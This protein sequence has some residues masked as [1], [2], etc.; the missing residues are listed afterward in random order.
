MLRWVGGAT[1]PQLRKILD[2]GRVAVLGSGPGAPGSTAYGEADALLARAERLYGAGEDSSAAAVYEM[3]LAHA[4]PE[5][6]S[7]SRAVESLLFTLVQTDA[8]L[9]AARLARD[10]YPHLSRTPSAANVAATG[11]DCALA[12]PADSAGRAELVA[13]LEADA[14][15]VVADSTV[16]VAADDRSAVYIALLDA[17]DDAKDAAGKRRW[18]EQWSAFL[19][20]VAA[21]APDARSAGPVRFPSIVG[22]HRARPTGA[23]DPDAR[24]LGARFPGR[25]QSTGATGGRLQGHEALGRCAGRIRPRAGQAYGPRKLGMFQVRSDIYLGRGDKTAAK[26]TLEDAVAYAE[27]LPEGPAVGPPPSRV[28]RRSWRR[29]NRRTERCHAAESPAPGSLSA[30]FRRPWS[31]GIIRGGPSSLPRSSRAPRLSLTRI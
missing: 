8:N 22:L 14:R 26:R 7:Y 17:R 30:A 2:D 12:I 5:W 28:S 11:L 31:T 6:P 15:A 19:D 1:V 3:A 24:G 16:P 20:G 29:S 13:A 9:R 25:L 18:A 27:A 23:R 21:R 4:S 10:A